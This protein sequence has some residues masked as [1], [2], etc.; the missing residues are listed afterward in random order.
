MKVVIG[1]TKNFS[2]DAISMNPRL[3]APYWEFSDDFLIKVRRLLS[4]QGAFFYVDEFILE[5][6]LKAVWLTAPSFQKLP[7]PKKSLLNS[8]KSCIEDL[9]AIEN[10]LLANCGDPASSVIFSKRKE[11]HDFVVDYLEFLVEKYEQVF[12]DRHSNGLR[13]AGRQGLPSK[14]PGFYRV[15]VM[16]GGS[17]ESFGLPISGGVDRLTGKRGFFAALLEAYANELDISGPYLVETNMQQ[18]LRLLNTKE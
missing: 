3:L 14:Y 12:V 16:L 5:L 10:L 9:K 6:E 7:K 11:Q 1:K 8:Y 13:S 15:A 17:M 2:L 18:L 4:E